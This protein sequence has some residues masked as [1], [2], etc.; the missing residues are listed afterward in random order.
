MVERDRL[1]L[2]LTKSKVMFFSC[3]KEKL[4]NQIKDKIKINIDSYVMQTT[5]EYK[6]LGLILDKRLKFHVT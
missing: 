2:N 6:Y 3:E 4:A 1:A 5:S